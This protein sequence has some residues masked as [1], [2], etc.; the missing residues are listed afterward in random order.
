[1]I[2]FVHVACFGSKL[3]RV[4]EYVMV[5]DYTV[6]VKREGPTWHPAS[7]SLLRQLANCAQ[8]LPTTHSNTPTSSPLWS[9][10][11]G[12]CTP[13]IPFKQLS[14]LGLGFNHRA[15]GARDLPFQH[16]SYQDSICLPGTKSP[17]PQSFPTTTSKLSSAPYQKPR[18]R[19]TPLLLLSCTLLTQPTA[20]DG[21]TRGCRALLC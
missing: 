11:L 20:T 10:W 13:L 12:C 21:P 7:A 18:T 15:T 8:Q 19:S 5:F 16:N 3:C 4:G 9:L 6:S 17:C 1:M 2:L 14:L